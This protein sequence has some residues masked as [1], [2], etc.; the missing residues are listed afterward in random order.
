MKKIVSTIIFLLGVSLFADDNKTVDLNITDTNLTIVDINTTTSID[1]NNSDTNITDLNL[2]TADQNKTIDINTT[3]EPIIIPQIKPIIKNTNI[4]VLDTSA[5][6]IEGNATSN[7]NLE[8]VIIHNKNERI[9]INSSVDENG[10]WIIY[11]SDIS[12]QLEDGIYDIYVSTKDNYENKSEV[13]SKKS[14]TRDTTISAIVQIEDGNSNKSD[15][16]I[17]ISESKSFFI[18]GQIDDD[19]KIKKLWLYSSNYPNNIVNIDPK[20]IKIRDGNFKIKST[21]IPLSKL[22]DGLIIVNLIVADAH[23]NVLEV[24][25]QINKDLTAPKKPVVLKS[26]KENNMIFGQVENML[27]FYG[28]SELNSK[29]NITV[30]NKDFPKNKTVATVKTDPTSKWTITGKD[31]EIKTIKDGDIVS[32]LVQIDE[33]GNRSKSLK[34]SNKKAKRSIF[35][36]VPQKIVSENYMSIHTIKN[37]EDKVK[38]IVVSDD[39]IIAGTFEFIYFFDKQK[40]EVKKKIEIKKKW[41][42]SLFLSDNKL[43]VALD[44][45]SIQ[46]R[47]LKTL[48]IIDKIKN[49]KTT[50]LYLRYDKKSKY[51]LSSDASGDVVAYDTQNKKTIYTLKK[52]QWDVAAIAIKDS[53]VY[54]GSDDYSIKIWD[55]K[56][57][58]LIKSLK[59]A[60]S[61]TINSLVVYKSWL[62]SASN[63]KTINIRDIKTGLL[64]KT[65]KGHNK[66]VSK[67]KINDNRLIS[68]SLDRTIII[69]NLKTLKKQK[70]LRGHSKS[71]ISL[72]VHEENIIT[73][74]L[75][76]TMRIWGY[77]ES[78][79]G[80][81]EIDETVL[82]K[83][84]LIKSMLLSNDT[85]TD[86]IQTENELVFSTYGYVY[87]YNNVTYRFTK[88]YTSLDKVIAQT[89]KKKT[90]SQNSSDDEDDGWG[91][92]SDQSE[93]DGWEDESD[94]SEDDGWEDEDSG[95]SLGFEEIIDER[96]IELE[97]IAKSNLQWIN[98]ISLNGVELMASLGY[99][100]LKVWD[101]ERNKATGLLEG[102]ENSVLSINKAEGMFVTSSSSGDIKIWDDESKAMLMSIEA[103]QWDVRD[104]VVDDMRLYSISDDYSIKIWDIETGDI[105]DTIK[106]AHDG[107]ITAILIDGNNIITSSKDGTIK[108]RD[109]NTGKLLKTLSSHTK[110]VNTI[111]K[112]ETHLISGSDDKTI[113]VWDLKTGKLISN[114][115]NGHTDGITALM[116]TEDYIISGAKD[117]K[118][119]IWKYY[120]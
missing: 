65:L 35:P 33:A 46:I 10:D 2:T 110:A 111:I 73:G 40:A 50:V 76:Y 44:D 83:Y 47:D 85:I 99:K 55:I 31:L 93:D 118:I 41:I 87:F 24:R 60:H 58:K 82:K 115:T 25:S 102:H 84:D 116:I 45:G 90:V 19:A 7:M 49:H 89:K 98:Q 86:I 5:M 103:H 34:I 88:L 62:I 17:N 3:L 112:D 70:Q 104:T 100:N 91:D 51:L 29:I 11:K 120:E 101:I 67:L 72:D 114:M 109:K 94:Q 21:N 108:Y 8:V 14:L 12:K 92:E 59:S 28:D 61:G 56:T 53:K 6:I 96:K 26:V 37:L 48:K 18:K 27:V 13:A 1:I 22:E 97:K 117:K 54:T 32:Y 80:Q 66:G 38:S 23:K 113:K 71:I 52:H 30:Y 119:S 36:K 68:A 74:S 78:L 63:D 81:G 15:D 95:G 43:F 64:I 77:D 39:Y 105:L 57:G 106:S 42:N 75:D 69:W 9:V 4:D 107:E 79:Q 20:K 16:F